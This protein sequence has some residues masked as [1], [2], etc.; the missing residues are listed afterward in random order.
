VCRDEFSSLPQSEMEK[1]HSLEQLRILGKRAIRI[2]QSPY[3]SISVDVPSDVLAV[4]RALTKHV[5]VEG[6]MRDHNE[7]S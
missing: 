3:C 5:V 2:V 4:E 7:R 6:N 1:L